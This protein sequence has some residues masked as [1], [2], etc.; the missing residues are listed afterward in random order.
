MNISQAT[1]EQA[2]ELLSFEGDYLSEGLPSSPLTDTAIFLSCYPRN[3]SAWAIVEALPGDQ[4]SH[5]DAERGRVTQMW[6]AQADA[7]LRGVG[8]TNDASALSWIAEATPKVER[9]R[10]AM[11]QLDNELAQKLEAIAFLLD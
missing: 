3:A 11:K 5:D 4:K 8:I 1:A 6:L 9:W 2:Y 7:H 10:K